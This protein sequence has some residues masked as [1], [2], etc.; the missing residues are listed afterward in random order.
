MNFK[1]LLLCILVFASTIK[2]AGAQK[3]KSIDFMSQIGKYDLSAIVTADSIIDEDREDNKEKIKRRDPL[4]FIGDNY[5]RFYIHITAMVK[6]QDKPAEYYVYGKTRVKNNI[7]DFIGTMIVTSCTLNP[8]VEIPGYKQGI[9]T[10]EVK[11]YED[12]KNSGAGL[13]TGKL[14]THFLIDKQ[15]KFRY[16]AIMLV[17]DGF[18]NN[19]FAGIWT[20]YQTKTVKKCNW[21]DYRIPNSKELDSGAGEFMVNEKYVKNGWENY[22]EMMSSVDTQGVKKARTEE[23]RKWWK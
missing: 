1:Q 14:E 17:A 4:G 18:S 6:S 7:C 19:Q 20:S 22:R 9:A 3:S 21:G 8:E 13:I 15:G 5:Q 12:A 16:D 11:L 23:E 10:F 2:Q